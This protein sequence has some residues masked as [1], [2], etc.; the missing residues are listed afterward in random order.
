MKIIDVSIP[1]TNE[2]LSE[3][4]GHPWSIKL[5]DVSTPATN[6][7]SSED[8]GHPQS[9]KLIDVS[10]PATNLIS[11]EDVGHPR[12]MKLIDVSTSATNETPS[13][14]V[15]HPRSMKLIDVSKPTTNEIPSEDV[16]HPRSM[17]LIDAS[18]P[19]T[20]AIQIED[21]GHP[22]SMKLIDVSTP[23]TNEIPSEDVGHPRS[24]KL[25]DVS[26]PTTNEIPSEDVGHPRSMKLIDAST[27]TTNAIQ[28][29]DARHPRPM[30]LIDVSI[31]NTNEIQFEDIGQ[32]RSM[33]LIDVSKPT[34]SKTSS[35]DAGH[36]RSIKLIDIS[37]PTTD[38]IPSKDVEHPRS[39]KLIDVSSPTTTEIESK[40]LKRDMEDSIALVNVTQHAYHLPNTSGVEDQWLRTSESLIKRIPNKTDY[41]FQEWNTIISIFSNRTLSR[42]KYEKLFPRLSV[43]GAIKEISNKNI[44]LKLFWPFV[45]ENSIMIQKLALLG[46]SGKVVPKEKQKLRFFEELE[47]IQTI[48]IPVAQDKIILSFNNPELVEGLRRAGLLESSEDYLAAGF[49]LYTPEDQL[50]I[51]NKVNGA[52]HVINKTSPELYLAITQIM[53]SVAL[54]KAERPVYAGGST[55]SAIG[56]M[57]QDPRAYQEFSVAHFAEQIVHEFIHTTLFMVDMVKG[58]FVDQR[59]FLK[60]KVWSPF[61]NQLRSYDRTFHACYV[62]TGKYISVL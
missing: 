4:V 26:K 1:T 59:K 37:I 29:E 7:I 24:M 52:M 9:M 38:K 43:S 34:T 16:G 39:M 15:G 58:L 49:H 36:P 28:I 11:S 54:Y 31:P 5:K 20:N 12:P 25:I 33:N 55:S 47:K 2:I 42:K 45:L 22:R 51:E 61:R 53:G 19:T 10:T 6:V 17:K 3:D 62:S 18:T 30:K 44:Y 41:Y 40:K 50:F 46:I 27:P 23:T 13:E 57:W 56:V 32:P 60:A 48:K 8:V 14:D 21:V 35:E